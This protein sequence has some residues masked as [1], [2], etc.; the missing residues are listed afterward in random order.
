MTS[1]TTRIPRPMGLTLLAKNYQKSQQDEDKNRLLKHLINNYSLQGFRYNSVPVS[2]PELA[3]LTG[4]KEALIMDYISKLN[5]DV[6][7]FNNPS[8]I[9]DTLKTIASVSMNWAFQ[10]RGLIMEQVQLLANAQGGSYKPFISSEVV[11]ALKLALDSNTNIQNLYKTFFTSNTTNILNVY[12]NTD[13]QEHYLTPDEAYQ[14]LDQHRIESLEATRNDKGLPAHN[15]T[16][17]IQ[18]DRLEELFEKHSLADTPGCIENRSG[19][20]A[21]RALEPDSQLA[22]EQ[23]DTEPISFKAPRKKAPKSSHEEFEKRRGEEYTD[24]DEID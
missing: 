12:N 6:G 21:L 5:E 14:I 10:D 2:I 18:K 9:Q 23:G 17:V 19:T 13:E 15:P 8:Q 1:V 11:K 3:Q 24:Y 4:L 16:M 20:E 22:D 7:S